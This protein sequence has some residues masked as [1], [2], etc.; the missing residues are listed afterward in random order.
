MVVL[1][2]LVLGTRR[3]Q[4]VQVAL[5]DSYWDSMAVVLL[6][7]RTLGD[8]IL[9]WDFRV[10]VRLLV[11][12]RDGNILDCVAQDHLPSCCQVVEGLLV[13]GLDGSVPVSWPE[14][15]GPFL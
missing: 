15:W 8:N 11:R 12:I 5:H 4:V 3:I 7:V 9:D 6:L 14:A 1:A 13:R 10:V 2:I